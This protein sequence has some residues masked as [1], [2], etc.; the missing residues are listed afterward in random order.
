MPACCRVAGVLVRGWKEEGERQPV[1]WLLGLVGC[2]ADA[3]WRQRWGPALDGETGGVRVSGVE[4]GCQ[5]KDFSSGL[6][7]HCRG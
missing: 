6:Q 2:L 4:G 1:D 7:Q 3:A 5:V